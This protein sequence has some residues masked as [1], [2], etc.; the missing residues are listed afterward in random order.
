MWERKRRAGGL[1][2]ISIAKFSISDSL[3]RHRTSFRLEPRGVLD[4]VSLMAFDVVLV[5]SYSST[6]NLMPILATSV[7]IAIYRGLFSPLI[8]R[9]LGRGNWF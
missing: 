1:N 8:A 4:S 5:Y 7:G 3:S 2:A 9:Y 6:V